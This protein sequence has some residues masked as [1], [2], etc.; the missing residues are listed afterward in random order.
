MSTLDN[1]Y[2]TL[3][4]KILNEGET[5]KNRTGIDTLSIPQYIFTFDASKEVPILTTKYVA[6]KGPIFEMLWIYKEQSNEV[7]WLQDRGVKIWN[8]WC[9]S[10]DGYYY[11][12]GKEPKFFGKEFAGT[13]G[14]AYGWIS[15]HTQNMQKLIKTIKEN[16]DDR[17]MVVSLWQDD[18]LNT[19][20]LPSCVWSTE[21]RV[22]NGKLNL[23]V[24]Q[25]SCD[26]ALGLPYNVYQYY[27]LLRLICQV[28]NLMPGNITWTIND[29]HIYVNH[30]DGIKEQLS[31]T[32]LDAPTLWI[33]PE[34][35]DF[36]AVDTSKELKDI[37]LENYNH[38]PSIK[39]DVAI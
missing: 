35:T 4:T 9:I 7:K 27:V 39:F 18:Y 1:I 19:A 10:N 16:P 12:P 13:I 30:I 36:F 2:N 28:T 15:K 29:A 17:R 22:L 6:P 21:W 34:L 32:P 26:V 23:M 25:R 31:R 20:V 38:H 8:E 11:A 14:T 3:C 37:K 24:H 5:V 33:N